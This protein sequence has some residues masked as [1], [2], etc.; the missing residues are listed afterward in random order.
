LFV[1]PLSFPFF[2]IVRPS[3]P[4]LQYTMDI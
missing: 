4:L 3:T 2:Y 1:L